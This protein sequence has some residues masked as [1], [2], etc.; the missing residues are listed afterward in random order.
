M[1]ELR[2]RFRGALLGAAVGDALG[3][4][5]EGA[6]VVPCYALEQLLE[7]PG[8]LCYTDDTH[9]MLG[10][11]ES[12]LECRGFDGRHMADTFARNYFAQPW[13]GYGSGPPRVFELIV[14]GEPWD[15]ASSL[16]FGGLGSYG[17][18]AAMRV[19]PAGLLKYREPGLAAEIANDSAL[20]THSHELG[21]EGA[22]LQ[23]CAVALLVRQPDGTSF[24]QGAFLA[25]L[26][27]YIRTPA[28]HRKM[29][30]IRLLLPAAAS[31]DAA[32]ALGN[33]VAAHESVPAAL[34]SFLSHA[35]SF[36]DAVIY[37]VSLGGDT[38]TIACMTG[39][40]AG[41]RL[42]E[43]AIPAVWRHRVEDA[44]RLREL[45]DALF[46]LAAPEL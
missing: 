29:E 13:R 14:R 1:Q 12:L 5:F 28:L 39:A 18:G 7:E 9:M 36:S 33:G 35:G 31:A 20:I 15:K 6:R 24:N 41:A 2:E 45:A 43:K 22:V 19:A 8:E 4:K 38:D 32:A 37:A 21:R 23:A 26:E 11:A 30:Q 42:G 25:D 17:N 10:M 34:Y 40:L 3:A 44:A 16:L 27:K 46:S